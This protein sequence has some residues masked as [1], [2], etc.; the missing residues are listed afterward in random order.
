VFKTKVGVNFQFR[1]INAGV[2]VTVTENT[3][4]ITISSTPTAAL[5][6]ITSISG[7]NYSATSAN[8]FIKAAN[9]GVNI[10]VTLPSAVGIAGKV[11]HIKKTDIGNTLFVASTLSQT[12]DGVDAT[13]TPI[14]ITVQNETLSIV[15]DG[16]NWMVI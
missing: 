4:D 11:L 10:T 9:S 6:N 16:A 14:A 3:N 12:I 5:L 2:G 7:V 15:S 8:D 1:K 13:A